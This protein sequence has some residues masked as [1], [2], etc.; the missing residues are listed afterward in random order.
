VTASCPIEQASLKLKRLT[1]AL[2]S[3]GQRQV[4]HVKLQLGIDRK[5]LH[6]LETAQDHRP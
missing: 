2:Q 5:I 6:Q 4:G 1:H 3:M